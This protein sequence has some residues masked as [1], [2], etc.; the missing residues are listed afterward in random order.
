M[1]IVLISS[2]VIAVLVAVWFFWPGT[3]P[4]AESALV[5]SLPREPDSLIPILSTTEES[6]YI[7]ELVFDGLINRTVISS[8]GRALYSKGLCQRFQEEGAAHRRLARLVG[9]GDLQ[10]GRGR[11]SPDTQG[12]AQRRGSQ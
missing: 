11:D 1:R 12:G 7:S 9:G 4:T 10:G 6:V 8:T 2:V 5:F 3:A